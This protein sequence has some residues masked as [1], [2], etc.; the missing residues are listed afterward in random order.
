MNVPQI[1]LAFALLAEWLS[2]SAVFVSGSSGVTATG[3][4]EYLFLSATN[5]LTLGGYYPV[6][7][8][9]RALTLAELACGFVT[10]TVTIAMLLSVVR[11]H[12]QRT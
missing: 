3:R 5:M 4:G 2:K 12:A 7:A 11:V 1:V 9:A 8:A 10:V 6:T